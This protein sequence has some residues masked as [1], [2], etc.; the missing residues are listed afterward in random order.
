MHQIRSGC[1]KGMPP[2]GGMGPVYQSG[3]VYGR[4]GT[5]GSVFKV[6]GDYKQAGAPATGKLDLIIAPSNWGN[7]SAGE[8]KVTVKSGG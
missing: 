3:A 6:G 5:G 7:E 4:I 1:G 8:Y 2:G